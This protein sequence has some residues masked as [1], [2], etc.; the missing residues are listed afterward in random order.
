MPPPAAGPQ[1]SPDCHPAP[2]L[3]QETAS[4][5]RSMGQGERRTLSPRTGG[6]QKTWKPSG[7]SNAAAKNI[8]DHV[9]LHDAISICCIIK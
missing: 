2:G 5:A 1:D 4:A 7:H 8:S 3:Q 6:D 9:P